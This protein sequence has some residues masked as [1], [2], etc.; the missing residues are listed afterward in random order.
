VSVCLDIAVT[1]KRLIF[2]GLLLVTAAALAQVEQSGAQKKGPQY[3]A[4]GHLTAYVYPDGT[5]DQYA[6]DS[7]WRLV[8]FIN[9]LGV[10]TVYGYGPNG[11]TNVAP[12]R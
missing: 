7:A 9:R 11:T 10:K 6:Y 1:M 3:D 2:A 4:E 12:A 8:V 5:R